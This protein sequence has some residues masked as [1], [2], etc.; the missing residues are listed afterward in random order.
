MSDRRQHHPRG[1][2]EARTLEEF[3]DDFAS[4]IRGQRSEYRYDSAAVDDPMLRARLQG[5]IATCRIMMAYL[6]DARKQIKE[7]TC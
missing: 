3:I 4:F 6:N 2:Q 7:G 1:P 5:Q